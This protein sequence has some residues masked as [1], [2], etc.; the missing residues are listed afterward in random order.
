[1]CK[2]PIDIFNKK[3]DICLKTILFY[4]S[5][6]TY[7]V[8]SFLL[9][10]SGNYAR[11]ACH[12]DER[13]V[14]YMPKIKLKTLAYNTI[15]SK[16]V[17]C[18]YAP[19]TFLSEEQLTT[20]LSLSRTPVRDALG[21]LEQE[22]LLE[23]RPKCGILVRPLTLNDI[24]MI[25]EVRMMYEPYVLTHYGGNLSASALREFYDIF[26]KWNPGK[27][28]YRDKDSFYDLDYRFHSLIMSAC[29]NEFIRRNYDTI[30]TQNER[31]RYMTGNVSN[32]RLE[33]TFKEH[34]AIVEPCLKGDWETAA[35]QLRDH[36][37]RSMSSAFQLVAKS[38]PG[39]LNV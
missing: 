21:R 22:G 38:N 1:M 14:F 35:E 6:D 25:F 19:G 37:E 34:L 10:R 13:Q 4:A 23:I 3:A 15:R 2:T 8:E 7:A 30:Q 20:E 9:I 29:P 18:Q 12:F 5:I 11:T 32:V 28:L 26:Q 39:F 17:T 27:E 36:L 16:I 33:A 31:F 24:D